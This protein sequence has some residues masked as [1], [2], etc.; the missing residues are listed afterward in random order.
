[1][2]I[3]NK[4]KFLE[5]MKQGFKRTISWNKYTSEITTQTKNNNVDCLND[6]AVRNINRLFVLSFKNG[7][8]D[9]TKDSFK[10]YYMPLAGTKDFNAFVDNK[11]F[12]DQPVKKTRS[13]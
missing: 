1:M 10:K 8:D 13:V 2:S 9:L 7:N 6:V 12:F 3:N 4:I 11:L 5:N